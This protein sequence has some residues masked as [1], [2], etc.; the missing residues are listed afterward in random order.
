[1]SAKARQDGV[2]TGCGPLCL[3]FQ[4]IDIELA[5]SV[6]VRVVLVGGLAST[7]VKTRLPYTNAVSSALTL[8]IRWVTIA[9]SKVQAPHEA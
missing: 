3:Q 5:E 8:S 4:T 2:W 6:I 1:M 9:R 7:G